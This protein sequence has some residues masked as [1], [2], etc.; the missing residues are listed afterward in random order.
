MSRGLSGT[1]RMETG[2]L[3]VDRYPV[4]RQGIM[5]L[6]QAD[7]DSPVFGEAGDYQGIGRVMKKLE[8]DIAVVDPAP[9]S[10]SLIEGMN[11]SYPE[12]PVLVQRHLFQM[13]F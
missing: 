9:R 5:S 10:I 3:V 4:V 1:E 6:L 12:L 13:I 8:P 2:V 11:N 7:A